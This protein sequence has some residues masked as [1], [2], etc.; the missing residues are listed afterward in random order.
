MIMMLEPNI[1]CQF[2]CWSAFAFNG[3]CDR[4]GNDSLAVCGIKMSKDC[5][6]FHPDQTRHLAQ[7][8]G[9]LFF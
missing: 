4:Q 8:I 9:S 6:L 1:I 5:L 2:V 3:V 7:N